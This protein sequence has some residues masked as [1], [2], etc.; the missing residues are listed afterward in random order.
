MSAIHAKLLAHLILA[1]KNHTP[2]LHA[3]GR[4][5]LYQCFWDI[6]KAQQCNLYRISAVDD[7]LHLVVSYPVT[8][9]L[10]GL[11]REL[12]TGSVKWMKTSEHF[13]D[14]PGW[15]EGFAAFSV[16]PAEKDS[17]VEYVKNQDNL[18]KHESYMDEYR[19]LLTA[20]GIPFDDRF[21]V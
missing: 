3:K 7:H 13:A 10:P 17:V 16:S 5:D 1:T 2:T 4:K 11:M 19:R 18:H 21:L 6:H 9:S 15:H 12:K 14:F 20:A 8:V